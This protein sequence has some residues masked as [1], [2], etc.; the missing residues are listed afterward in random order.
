MQ[1]VNRKSCASPGKN[2]TSAKP[3]SLEAD[4][5]LFE[6]IDLMLKSDTYNVPVYHRDVKIADLKFSDITGF[7]SENSEMNLLFHKL[8]YT[9]STFLEL[10]TR[11]QSV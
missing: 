6:A 7:L 3:M 1:V 11:L 8:N 9:V 2:L 4:Q 10:R 5:L